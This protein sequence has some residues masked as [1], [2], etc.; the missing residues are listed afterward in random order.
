M[1][2][3]SKKA[4]RSARQKKSLVKAATSNSEVDRKNDST[5]DGNVVNEDGK[6]QI[7][8]NLLYEANGWPFQSPEAWV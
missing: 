8:D 4:S 5:G 7:P 1:S 3:S 2:F 6:L